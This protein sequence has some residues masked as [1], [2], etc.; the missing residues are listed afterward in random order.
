MLAEFRA[1]LRETAEKARSA[2]PV[3]PPNDG[4]DPVDLHT[5]LGQFLALRHEV[6]LQTKAV[7]AQ[8]EQN[9]ETLR[10]LTQA[11]DQLGRSSQDCDSDEALRPLLKTLV[12]LYDALALGQREALRVQ[13][14][15]LAATDAPIEPPP[16]APASAAATSFW[17]A[18]FGAGRSE[19]EAAR[20]AAEERVQ[21]LNQRWDRRLEEEKERTRGLLESLV[22]GYTMSLQ[23]LERALQHHGL[24][25]I[26]CA[27]APFD[28]ELMEVVEAVTD[29]GRPAG[30][31]VE[32]MR[33]GY[34]WGG[35]VFRYA[36][37][38]VAK[39]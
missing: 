37:V 12:D 6:H 30:E 17:S 14:A 1:W 35:R 39:P 18:L 26:R 21:S 27:G 34:L 5:L 19:A 25:A 28:P 33:R 11:L 10:Q 15:A 7:R 9:A 2:P 3:A 20:R 31:V 22:T 16:E 8:Q 4:R 32:E 24:E 13:A 23:R 38:R 29:S 36:L